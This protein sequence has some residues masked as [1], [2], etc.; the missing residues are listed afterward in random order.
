M[1]DISVV[2]TDLPDRMLGRTDGSVIYIDADAAGYGWFI[3]TTPYDSREFA[4][5]VEDDVLVAA[6][7]GTAFGE[8]DLLTVVSHEIGHALGFDHDDGLAV[9]SDELDAGV[10][11]VLEPSSAG[12]GTQTTSG[13][14]PRFDFDLEVGGSKATV[15]W[16]APPAKGWGSTLS[17]Y[18]PPSASKSASE[19]FVDFLS[20]IFK[21]RGATQGDGFDEMGRTLLGKGDDR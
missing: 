8:M 12:S 17:P 15:D 9:M 7:G 11:Y 2:I 20:K 1:A 16:D 13:A 18:A 5:R 19:N 10:R 3:D 6:P 14:L 21:G 4:L